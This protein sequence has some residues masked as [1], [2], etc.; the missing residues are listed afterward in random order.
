MNFRG[1]ITVVT[2]SGE[3]TRSHLVIRNA[4]QSDEGNYTCKPSILQSASLRLFVID[5]EIHLRFLFLSFSDIRRPPCRHA[6]L[7]KTRTELQLQTVNLGHPSSGN[8]Q[9]FSD[10]SL[11]SRFSPEG[12][13]QMFYF[14]T[15]PELGIIKKINYNI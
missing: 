2:E 11:S 10:Q 1:G 8:S 5:G 3:E 13:R 9:F 7:G 14:D 15:S 12:R 4:M 6:H